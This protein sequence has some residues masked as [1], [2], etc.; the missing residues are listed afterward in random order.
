[1]LLKEHVLI[2]LSTIESTE[3]SSYADVLDEE[4]SRK[5]ALELEIL[6]AFQIFEYG[7]IHKI[8]Y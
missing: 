8:L 1:M 2:K 4:L 5:L 6:D 7:I 3:S